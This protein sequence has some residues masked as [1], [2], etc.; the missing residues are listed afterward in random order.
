MIRRHSS[1]AVAVV[2]LLS[3]AVVGQ[4][5]V[6]A[7]GMPPVTAVTRQNN[8]DVFI[9]PDDECS[10]DTCVGLS[11]GTATA[12]PARPNTGRVCTCRCLNHLPAYRD[13]LRICVDDIHECA[14]AP[15]VGGSTSQQ[16]PFVFLPLKGQIVYPS[17]EISFA[18]VQTPI[19]AVSGAQFLTESG[20]IELRSPIDSDV[21][22][23]LF[24]DEG[25]TFLQWLGDADL[26]AKM[27]GRLILIQMLCKD[28]AKDPTATDLK[29]VFTPCV[30]F[31]VAGTPSKYINNVS[32]VVFSPDAQAS[33]TSP[34]GGLTVSEYIA[35]GIC[36]V[37]L[38]LIYVSSVFL[39]LHI[40]RRKRKEGLEK[41]VEGRD[42]DISA[43]EEGIIKNNP[44]LTLG[45]HFTAPDN[46][47]S[48]SGSS[49]N[50]IAP[51][52]LQHSDESRNKLNT[53]ITSA[54]VHSM[55]DSFSMVLSPVEPMQMQ[56]SSS[57]ERLPEE[58]VSIVETLECREER[59]ETVKTIVNATTRRK[60]YFNPAYFEPQLL[61]APPP[62]AIE[63]LTK[64]REVIAIAKH[65]MAT[66]RFA[67][68]LLGIPEEE[69]HRSSEPIYEFSLGHASSR[70]SSLIS[71]KRENSR[72][73][74][75]QC[76]G[77]PGCEP[78]D[79]K[80]LC[81]K[82]PEF[83]SIAICQTCSVSSVS[84]SKQQSI[85]KWL[86]DVPML[87]PAKDGDLPEI[88]E[89]VSSSP[90]LPEP[91]KNISN[92]DSLA[93]SPPIKENPISADDK[94]S[95]PLKSN[96]ETS[97][98]EKIKSPGIKSRPMKAKAPPPPVATHNPKV[99]FHT[100]KKTEE[101]KPNISGYYD[102]IRNVH[103]SAPKHLPP[104]DMINEAIV[105]DQAEEVP[106]VTK[107]LFG[108]VINEFAAHCGIEMDK[109]KVAKEPQLKPSID[110]IQTGTVEYET[111]SLERNTSGKNGFSTP[112]DYAD[113]SSSQPSPSLSTALP[114]DEEMT[115][116]NE[117]LQ[118]NTRNTN[119]TPVPEDEHHYELIVLNKQQ[120]KV[121]SDMDKKLYYL[122]ELL[123]R[124]NGYNFVSEVYVNN[125]YNFGSAPST[126][127]GSNSSTLEKQ[128]PKI[129]YEQPE[130]KPGHLTIEVEDCPDN[131]IKIDSDCFEPDTLDRKQN[132][133]KSLSSSE[134]T[135]SCD[136][137]DSLERPRQILL[138]TTGSFKSDTLNK[139]SDTCYAL[140]SNF[141]RAFG[142]LRE[143]YEAKT[144]NFLRPS[145]DD[146]SFLGPMSF[147]SSTENS[148]KQL[149]WN[150]Y[151]EDEDCKLLT[152]DERQRRRQR[153]SPN[154]TICQIPPDVIPPSPIQSPIYEHPKPPRKVVLDTD[155]FRPPLP[156][157]NANG[158]ST[159]MKTSSSDNN[160][161][162]SPISTDQQYSQSG[163]SAHN[164]HFSNGEQ[165]YKTFN[166]DISP[167]NEKS[168]TTLHDF[169][170]TDDVFKSGM[171]NQFILHASRL[172][173]VSNFNNTFK[174][175]PPFTSGSA[176]TKDNYLFTTNLDKHMR[177][178]NKTE[179][180][181]KTWRKLVDSTSNNQKEDSGYLST[182]SNE[183]CKRKKQEQ[184][185]EAEKESDTDESLGDGHSES[186]AESIETHS[187]F[188][189]T[190]RKFLRVS[191]SID[192]GVGSDC[193]R[194][195]EDSILLQETGSHVDNN[196]VDNTS[197]G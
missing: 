10:V 122:P 17:K 175:A 104:P 149:S 27:A 169:I 171:N 97:L 102:V 167:P 86:E 145:L 48:D 196:N 40:R 11:S 65:K 4:A 72:R 47:F 38:G 101:I 22:F 157:K 107:K 178:R 191:G 60:L 69:N 183:S 197:P 130:E 81:G 190:Y 173:S 159:S 103:S 108:S 5:A 186:G 193:L 66:K 73:K 135:S 36:S 25:R 174:L 151:K 70:R 12:A 62:A 128:K 168:C 132:K 99:V 8:G 94:S 185:Q 114:L 87:H 90:K 182:D 68:S 23:R 120:E 75:Q 7:P 61:L 152:L 53:Q 154:G 58:N 165:Y 28:L 158:R 13:D 93:K 140:N 63:F 194:Y 76:S 56:D 105:V 49:D 146:L 141:N 153:Q 115:M 79:L 189:G 162:T 117:I 124:K 119:S 138:R 78:N 19:C 34:V 179:S 82:L 80:S 148:Q 43:V 147:S 187:V 35:I 121:Q 85:R 51:D 176:N 95:S 126:P 52:I 163:V 37:L 170:R 150:K 184:V 134:T 20:W 192:S 89:P 31:R 50:E 137:I 44:L 113:V 83:P 42:D 18:G 32:E 33:D 112:T 180:V 133:S 41:E 55:S 16:I 39:Y 9:A 181:K 195:A 64:I 161:S 111:D 188:F 118:I 156:P 144:R 67:P 59:P 172:S 155:V 45:R 106:P 125:G 143:I 14:L 96:K 21:P 84:E 30:A 26:R 142:S 6:S 136:Y 88:E 166:K 1:A 46:T 110:G 139:S 116:R 177:D 129:R 2:A 109:S 91:V 15:F 98:D 123:Q 3:M 77:C 131:Y 24:R 127:S 54:I 74:L 160:S 100:V 57:I 92:H 71:L 29:S 164:S